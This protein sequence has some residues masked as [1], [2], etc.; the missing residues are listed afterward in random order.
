MPSVTLEPRGAEIYDLCCTFRSIKH[1]GEKTI[2]LSGVTHCADT[3]LWRF[4][5]INFVFRLWFAATY[6]NDHLVVGSDQVVE[7][8]RHFLEYLEY[9]KTLLDL[10]KEEEA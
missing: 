2:L 8:G 6:P 9:L 4:Q 5:P 7:V 1:E 10:L 3:G